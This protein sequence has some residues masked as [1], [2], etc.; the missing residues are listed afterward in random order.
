MDKY[1]THSLLERKA[2]IECRGEEL[3]CIFCCTFRIIE[4]EKKYDYDLKL[5]TSSRSDV[6]SL[7]W[8]QTD[9]ETPM[10]GW[11]FLFSALD[12]MPAL[13]RSRSHFAFGNN[14]NWWNDTTGRTTGTLSSAR[15][16][17]GRRERTQK[18][19]MRYAR[20]SQR[21]LTRMT[22]PVGALATSMNINYSDRDEMPRAHPRRFP[23]TWSLSCSTAADYD[24]LFASSHA[25]SAFV[26]SLPSSHC[27][28]LGH[29]MHAYVNYPNK[30]F[31][32]AQNYDIL[33]Y[34][35]H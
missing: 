26:Y 17:L 4:L 30:M 28:S 33:Y 1:F 13:V 9:V 29:V 34:A 14:Y 20:S 16:R 10:D 23:H 6:N 24:S 22:A 8:V 21:L 2:H 7:V 31:M 15:D 11:C 18:T 27:S 19:R 12:V 35:S 25:A 3:N 5:Y 32:A